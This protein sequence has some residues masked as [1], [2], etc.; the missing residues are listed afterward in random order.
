MQVTDFARACTCLQ[1]ESVDAAAVTVLQRLNWPTQVQ[2]TSNFLLCA[3]VSTLTAAHLRKVNNLLVFPDHSVLV[4]S[5][6]EAERVLREMRTSLPSAVSVCLVN[7]AMTRWLYPGGRLV[8][9]GF[10]LAVGA[11]SCVQEIEGSR[12]TSA[13]V[14]ARLFNGESEY[15]KSEAGEAEADRMRRQVVQAVLVGKRRGAARAKVSATECLNGVKS[16]VEMRGRR[17]R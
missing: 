10:A 14:A 15:L 13:V 5:E 4:I 8:S 1:A 9:G 17:L 11:T 7:L 3:E 2:L 6:R 16:L 12:L